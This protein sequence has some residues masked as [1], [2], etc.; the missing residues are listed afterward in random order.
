MYRYNK[1]KR[2]VTKNNFFKKT[3]PQQ[4]GYQ[5]TH[6]WHNNTEKQAVPGISLST[7]M[8]PGYVPVRARCN[9]NR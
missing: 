8:P 9:L 7:I 3:N 5:L 1:N 4:P 2:E 6:T